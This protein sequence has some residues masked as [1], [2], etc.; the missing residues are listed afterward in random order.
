MS[1]LTCI[2]D[3]LN[4]LFFIVEC[5]E[6]TCWM[7]LAVLNY[8]TVRGQSRKNRRKL[9]RDFDLCYFL[10]TNISPNY[11]F[12]GFFFFWQKIYFSLFFR[13]LRDVSFVTERRYLTQSVNEKAQIGNHKTWTSR[14]YQHRPRMTNSNMTRITYL[15]AD[16]GPF[17][18]NEMME[19]LKIYFRIHYNF[20]RNI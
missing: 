7:S 16:F 13:Y 19:I 5:L 6:I 11:N 9:R 1:H 2:S 8:Q 10:N 15:G 3:K 17:V 20:K 12:P 14:Y 4:N 18:V